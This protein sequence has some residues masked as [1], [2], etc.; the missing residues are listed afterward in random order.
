MAILDDEVVLLATFLQQPNLV[1]GYENLKQVF[2]T[3]VHSKLFSFIYDLALEKPKIDFF[4]IV[5]E[6]KSKGITD[7][8]GGEE[9]LE[10][11]AK[12]PIQDV[13]IKDL[14][15]NLIQAYKKRSFLSYIEK[16][17]NVDFPAD[18]SSEIINSVIDTLSKLNTLSNLDS[19]QS[20][21]SA[22][23]TAFKSLYESLTKKKTITSGFYHLDLVT[24]GLNKGDL[25]Y[26]AGRPRMGKTAWCVNA[27]NAQATANIPTLL[28]SLEM[29]TTN[30]VYRLLSLR[31]NIPILNLKLGLVSDEELEILSAE[32]EKIKAL[33][34]FIDTNFNVTAD[35]LAS[36]I[37]KYKENHGIEVVHIDYLQLIDIGNY[38]N[39]VQGYTKL[40]RNLKVLANRFEVSI[41]CYSQLNRNVEMRNDKRPLLHDLRESGSLEQDADLV[42]MLYRD[43]IYNPNSENKNVLENLIRKHREGPEGVLF[44]DFNPET[45][46][47]T[48]RI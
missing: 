4:T 3:V 17:H 47:I 48:E 46:K 36:V 39:P 23:E 30:L 20:M 26:I 10:Y 24:G 5:S 21:E 44:S 34:I 29:N 31:T 25:W 19:V 41:L 13:N 7:S 8:V 40:S 15:D 11:L 2:S 16:F 43:D 12:V 27:I 14:A 35:Y 6:L 42:I 45:N 28:F 37:R 22:S 9:Y 1:L 32:K 18:K 33:P 38:E